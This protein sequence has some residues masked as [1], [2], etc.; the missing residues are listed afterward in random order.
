MYNWEIDAHRH[1]GLNQIFVLSSGQITASID[2]A[3]S[4]SNAPVALTIPSQCVH[5]FRFSAGSEGFVITQPRG[6]EWQDILF[7]GPLR[8]EMTADHPDLGR[9]LSILELL[10]DEYGR[11]DSS[12]TAVS[13]SLLNAALAVFARINHTSWRT[14]SPM[15]RRVLQYA[16]F[17]G[18]VDAHFLDHWPIRRYAST[19]NL[20]ESTLDRL[21][22]TYGGRTAFQTVQDR[23]LLEAKRLLIYTPS[24]IAVVAQR[25]GFA[26]QAYFSRF[27]RARTG[28]PPSDLRRDLRAELD[29]PSAVEAPPTVGTVRRPG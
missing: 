13:L 6:R 17:E 18:L 9:L 12:A 15:G 25:L 21:C 7:S 23:V 11:S 29:E 20:S 28:G 4:Q 16:A 8:I 24:S 3:T 10:F 14:G 1:G 27:I 22:R 26:D 19:L 2:G 5:A